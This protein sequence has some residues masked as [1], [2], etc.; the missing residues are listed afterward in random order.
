MMSV[1]EADVMV[2]GVFDTN[3]GLNKEK[4][5]LVIPNHAGFF[6]VTVFLLQ[7]LC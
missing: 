5:C 1:D 4:P 7:R 2:A 6:F 3:N